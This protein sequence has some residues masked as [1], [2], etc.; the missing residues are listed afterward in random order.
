[1]KLLRSEITI[2]KYRMNYSVNC[3]I[4]SSWG[5]FTDKCVITLPTSLYIN[6]KNTIIGTDNVFKRGD[7]VNIKCGYDT[8]LTTVFDGYISGI[9][10]N[11]PVTIECQ[12]LMWLLKQQ[13]IASQSWDN[14]TLSE[15]ME[16]VLADVDIEVDYVGVEKTTSI[17][18]FIIDNNSVVNIVQV[19]EEIKSQLSLISYIRD[20]KLVIGLLN[21]ATAVSHDFGFQHN[22]ISNSLEYRRV[23]DVVYSLKGVATLDDN[24]KVTRY[25]WYKESVFTITDADPAGNQFTHNVYYHSK[26]Q[27]EAKILLDAE[28]TRRFPLMIYEGYYGSFTTFLEPKCN[29][30]DIVTLY[31]KKYKERNGQSY[32]INKIVTSFGNNGGR[33]EITLGSRA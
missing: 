3:S 9:Q 15:L 7:I 21:S 22:I 24:T 11:N 28:L 18:A 25:A 10:P 8:N 23:D 19:L 26:T 4:E 2:G 17:G 12:D 6:N 27:A 20:G 32:Y 5:E 30:G 1:M 16:Y 29:H 14:V 13:N 33:Q 31:D